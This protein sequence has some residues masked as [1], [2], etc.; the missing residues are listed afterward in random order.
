MKKITI[1]FLTLLFLIINGIVYT[2]TTIN[3]KERIKLVLDDNLQT[4]QTHYDILLETQKILLKHSI[5]QL[6]TQKKW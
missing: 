3:G 1:L 2:M 6:L 5:L 4:L